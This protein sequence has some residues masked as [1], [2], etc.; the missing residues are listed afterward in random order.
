MFYG[1]SETI[2]A[3]SCSYRLV[4]LSL[5]DA[6]ISGV[7]GLNLSVEDFQ[8]V[9]AQLLTQ[10]NAEKT[11]TDEL[12]PPL[13]LGEVMLSVVPDASQVCIRVFF[14]QG[15]FSFHTCMTLSVCILSFNLCFWLCN[16]CTDISQKQ[17][18]KGCLVHIGRNF[19]PF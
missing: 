12:A 2:T 7:G 3:I 6:L 5:K 14:L 17:K 10:Q 9:A 4:C 16:V 15:D 8:N 19:R 18:C 13:T 11:T 1:A